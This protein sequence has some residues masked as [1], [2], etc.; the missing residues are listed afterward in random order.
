MIISTNWPPHSYLYVDFAVVSGMQPYVGLRLVK[1]TY[2]IACQYLINFGRRLEHWKQLCL[3]LASITTFNLP[4]TEGAIGLWHSLAHQILCRIFKS[5]EFMPG[6]GRY[7]GEGMERL[8]AIT[9]DVSARTK[10][11]TSGHRHDVLNDVY[12]DL[13]V[14]RVHNIGMMTLRRVN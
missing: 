4:R 3:P 12:S 6:S 11:M 14:R 7:E 13:H 8:W 10:E 2:D 5:P 9:N 1:Q